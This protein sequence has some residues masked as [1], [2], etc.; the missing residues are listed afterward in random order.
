MHQLAPYRRLRRSTVGFASVSL[1]TATACGSVGTPA[2]VSAVLALL[3]L[4]EALA[5]AVGKGDDADGDVVVLECAGCPGSCAGQERRRGKRV[6]QAQDELWPRVD[7]GGYPGE[8]EG[9]RQ[10]LVLLRA[11][12][13]PLVR[14]ALG[15][16]RP[17]RVGAV[18]FD[19][20]P[21]R[22][23]E[24][25]GFSSRPSCAPRR[26][27]ITR[28]A[29]RCSAE[30]LAGA[31]PFAMAA[32]SAGAPSWCTGALAAAG[33]PPGSRSCAPSHSLMILP[34]GPGRRRTIPAC[35]SARQ[36]WFTVCR[37]EIP[38]R[39]IPVRAAIWSSFRGWELIR[40]TAATRSR[41]LSV[42]MPEVCSGASPHVR[43]APTCL[44]GG[45]QS[46]LPRLNQEPKPEARPKARDRRFWRTG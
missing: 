43:D 13:W 10:D 9:I 24:V 26:S 34:S 41:W 42:D 28:S 7:G 27:S 31:A 33:V 11:L 46:A 15:Q 14:P 5:Q 6:A 19:G 25:A 29:P 22:D 45:R 12:R 1:L 17:A 35:S 18:D 30:S 4:E 23:S 8:L 36:T 38:V 32:G 39:A 40:I 3:R 21:G 44:R 16:D 2:G 20:L 37:G